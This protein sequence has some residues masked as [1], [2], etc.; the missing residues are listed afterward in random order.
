MSFQ[1]FSVL[2]V[3]ELTRNGLMRRV[4]QSGHIHKSE[5]TIA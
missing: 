3:F 1:W 2:L 5:K 4:K